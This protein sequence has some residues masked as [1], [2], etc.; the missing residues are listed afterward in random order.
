MQV[1]E[2]R[3]VGRQGISGIKTGRKSRLGRKVRRQGRSSRWA[4]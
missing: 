4:G 1:I 3:H 2:S